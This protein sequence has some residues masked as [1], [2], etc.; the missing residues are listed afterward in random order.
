VNA[1]IDTNVLLDVLA[2]R[3]PFYEDSAAVWTLAEQG[4]IQGLVS[5]VSFTNIF[6]VMRRW[7]GAKAA[8]RAMVLLRDAFTPVPCDAM[9]INQAI[10]GEVED[11]EDAVQYFSALHVGADCILSRDPAGF[12]R[13]PAVPVLTPAEFLARLRED[14]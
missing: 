9:I 14:S 10:D 11:F 12:P 6:Y 5:T 1:F 4:G 8:R 3:E 2:K 7:G 13:E